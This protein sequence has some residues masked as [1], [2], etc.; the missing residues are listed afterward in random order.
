MF[1]TWHQ[2]VQAIGCA[3]TRDS[4]QTKLFHCSASCY[5][6]PGGIIAIVE[7]LSDVAILFSSAGVFTSW[8]IEKFEPA[9]IRPP[10]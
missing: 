1:S 7:I 9:V 2:K 4:R 5:C 3:N 6:G 8:N 10:D